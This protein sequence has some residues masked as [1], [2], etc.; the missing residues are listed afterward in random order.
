MKSSKTIIATLVLSLFFLGGTAIV[1][2]AAGTQSQQKKQVR[3]QNIVTQQYRYTKRSG[4]ATQAG[5]LQRSQQ[6]SQQ[7]LQIRTGQQAE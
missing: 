3:Q 2:E 4:N 1:A 6:R 7:Q 5:T